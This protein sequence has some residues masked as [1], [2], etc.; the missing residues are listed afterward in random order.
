MRWVCFQPISQVI[1]NF[2]AGGVAITR[3]LRETA[4]ADRFDLN[5]EQKVLASVN[6]AKEQTVQRDV[7]P[8][9]RE[10]PL[11]GSGKT[12]KVKSLIRIEP[13]G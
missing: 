10:L 8:D 13:H 7:L 6:D 5:G 3:I 11:V 12:R 9:A 4:E 2:L 1:G